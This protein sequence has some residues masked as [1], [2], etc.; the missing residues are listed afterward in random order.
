MGRYTNVKTNWGW[1]Y[2][3]ILGALKILGHQWRLLVG[4]NNHYSKSCW[5]YGVY[6]RSSGSYALR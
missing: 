3:D 5:K 4:G 1:P 6:I 2:P